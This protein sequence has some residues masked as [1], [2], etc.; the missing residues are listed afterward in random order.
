MLKT[1]TDILN[2]M[3][4]N[5]VALGTAW[6]EYRKVGR[7]VTEVESKLVTLYALYYSFP[8]LEDNQTDI[9]RAQYIINI[10]QL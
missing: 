2:E 5:F 7:D 3:S 10:T 6:I 4:A 9:N 8:S 1:L